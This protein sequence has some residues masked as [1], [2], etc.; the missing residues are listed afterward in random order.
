M[1][2]ES[3]ARTAFAV[4]RA[5]EKYGAPSTSLKQAAKKGV[6]R[7]LARLD[8]IKPKQLKMDN[9]IV[10]TN[11]GPLDRVYDVLDLNVDMCGTVG[12]LAGW[13]VIEFKAEA[14]KEDLPTWANVSL[15]AQACLGLSDDESRHLF[16]PAG[17]DHK[18]KFKFEDAHQTVVRFWQTGV[19]RW[20]PE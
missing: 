5:I 1:N 12:C 9:F 3:E 11:T 13:T 2:Y 20:G 17:Y 6:A 19:I 15:Y 4:E 10:N 18:D 8:M 14:A 7:L 16:Y